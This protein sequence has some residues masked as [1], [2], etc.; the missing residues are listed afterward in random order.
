MATGLALS[1][2][3]TLA[4]CG[5]VGMRS[6]LTADGRGEDRSLER[7]ALAGAGCSWASALSVCALVT[8]RNVLGVAGCVDGLATGG[9]LTSFSAEL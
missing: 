5:G 6:Y 9:S 3:A 7:G 8:V 4:V 1:T 2:S